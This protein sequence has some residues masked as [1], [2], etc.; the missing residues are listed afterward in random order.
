MRP[1]RFGFFCLFVEPGLALVDDVL[2]CRIDLHVFG[3]AVG[4]LLVGVIVGHRLSEFRLVGRT[5]ADDIEVVAL[6]HRAKA[7]SER[8]AG[9]LDRRSVHTSRAVDHKGDLDRD[10]LDV[11]RGSKGC[12]YV[13]V[14]FAVMDYSS[15]WPGRLGR[16]ENEDEVAVHA[17]FV[18][19]ETDPHRRAVD[20]GA[21]AVARGL[22]RTDGGEKVGLDRCLLVVAVLLGDLYQAGG[23]GHLGANCHPRQRDVLCRLPVGDCWSNEK[24]ACTHDA[25]VSVPRSH[26]LYRGT[27]KTR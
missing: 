24:S 26:G 2:P 20:L 11:D 23:G 22:H 5:E 7:E 4:P 3:C 6:L 1:W 9:V 17:A 13:A 12:H 25:V 10:A 14:A 8:A 19:G 27:I 15:H 21:D 18:A 16:G